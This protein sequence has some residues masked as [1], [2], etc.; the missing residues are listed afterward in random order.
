M[1]VLN[2]PAQSPDMNI[3]ELVWTYMEKGAC[4][5]RAPVNMQQLWKVLQ[6]IRRNIPVDFIQKPY[7]IVPRTKCTKP[8][9]SILNIEFVIY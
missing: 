3:I 9:G 8:K 4:M 7:D 5:K 6:Y 1:T 2:C